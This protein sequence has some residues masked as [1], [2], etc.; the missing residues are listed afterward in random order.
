MQG[1]TT[2]AKHN[3]NG[4]LSLFPAR[5]QGSEEISGGVAR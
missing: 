5:V 2:P 1:I 4:F 3:V